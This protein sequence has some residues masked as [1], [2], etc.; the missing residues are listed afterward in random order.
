MS[1]ARAWVSCTHPGRC[2]LS[3]QPLQRPVVGPSIC[4]PASQIFPHTHYTKARRS[5]IKRRGEDPCKQTRELPSTPK[6]VRL[7]WFWGESCLGVSGPWY[8]ERPIRTPNEET[9]SNETSGQGGAELPVP[10]GVQEE[11]GEGRLDGLFPGRNGTSH[12]PSD[13]PLGPY[14]SSSRDTGS[15][16]RVRVASFLKRPSLH[17]QVPQGNLV[18]R[19]K[20]DPAQPP[21]ESSSLPLPRPPAVPGSAGMGTPR[22]QGGSSSAVAA[23]L[24]DCPQPHP[25]T[26]QPLPS[27]PAWPACASPRPQGPGIRL[28]SRFRECHLPPPLMV[29][30]IGTSWRAGSGGAEADSLLRR[31]LSAQQKAGGRSESALGRQGRESS[32]MSWAACLCCCLLR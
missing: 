28:E 12:P 10:E 20:D 2:P 25:I 5:V 13:Q 17:C 15:E 7:S 18:S 23:L 19:L 27:P 26:A 32:V 30:I 4:P 11:T 6:P 31:P 29:L 3:P 1:W 14:S 22:G 9:L 21:Q 24:I 8:Q 16:G